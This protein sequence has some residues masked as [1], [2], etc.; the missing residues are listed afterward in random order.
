MSNEKVMGGSEVPHG[1]GGC[2]SVCT[3]HVHQMVTQ[4][5][6][7]WGLLYTKTNTHTKGKI[8]MRLELKLANL[9]I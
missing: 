3:Q 1:G 8:T 2:V 6:Q 4:L 7:T 9:Q 5:S